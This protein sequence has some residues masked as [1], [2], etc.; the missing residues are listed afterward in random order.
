MINHDKVKEHLHDNIKSENQ[1]TILLKDC[2]LLKLVN[3]K[4]EI[5]K[6]EKD[7]IFLKKLHYMESQLFSLSS[8][9]LNNYFNTNIFDKNTP[10]SSFVIN[11]ILNLQTRGSYKDSL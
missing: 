10:M 6:I 9:K 1:L 4:E 5:K 11:Y 3:Y 7:Y 2:G 8:L